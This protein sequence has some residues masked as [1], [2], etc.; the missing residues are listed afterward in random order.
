MEERDDFETAFVVPIEDFIDLHT[1]RPA[2]VQS[3]VEEYL[4]AA[5]RKGFAVVRIIHGRGIGVLREMVQSILRRHPRVLEFSDAPDR[6]ATVVRFTAPG[7]RPAEEPR[8]IT[9]NTQ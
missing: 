5:E 3:V 9:G 8:D 7:P 1:F 2:E 6:G 4:D